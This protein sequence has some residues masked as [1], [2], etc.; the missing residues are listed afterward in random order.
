M[1]LIIQ[2]Q[3]F[4]YSDRKIH[5]HSQVS[6]PLPFPRGTQRSGFYLHKSPE[7]RL[8]LQVNYL[9]CR[10]RQDSDYMHVP[11][12]LATKS[13]SL[14]LLGVINECL[15]IETNQL[16]LHLKGKVYMYITDSY[17]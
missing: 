14:P 17:I 15:E 4:M 13:A 3:A 7:R 12:T 2:K 5:I 10:G 11:R 9:P 8:L 1:L 16:T 6:L